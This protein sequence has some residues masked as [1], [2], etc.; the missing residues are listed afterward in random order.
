MADDDLGRLTLPVGARDHAQGPSDAAVTLVE[1][2][3]YE[4]PHCGRAYP[5]VKEVQRRLG[6][7]L[8]FVFRNFPLNESHPR[9]ARCGSRRRRRGQDRFWEMHDGCSSTSG[10]RR[11]APRRI[12][13]ALGLDPVA[14]E[15][16]LRAHSQDSGS[17]G[18][19]E[20]RR[21]GVSTPTFFINGLRFDDSWDPDTLTDALTA[22]ARRLKTATSL[23]PKRSLRWSTVLQSRGAGPAAVHRRASDAAVTTN[24]VAE[25]DRPAACKASGGRNERRL[26]VH[27]PL[28]VS[29]PNA[30][31]QCDHGPGVCGSCWPVGAARTSPCPSTGGGVWRPA[32]HRRRPA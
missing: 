13:E 29:H 23:D 7:T 18:L 20:R 16:D 1:Y 21:S 27:R 26:D 14:F 2:G 4:C 12:C 8:R 24:S 22:A 6:S 30:R 10:P 5:I 19:P 11:S 17:R 32:A 15:H 28:D 31:R 25:T 3:D 9:P